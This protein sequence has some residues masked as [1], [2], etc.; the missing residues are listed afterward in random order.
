MSQYKTCNE[1]KRFLPNSSFSPTKGGKFGTRAKCKPCCAKA[2]KNY[3]MRNPTCAAE[4]SKTYR[5]RFPEIVKANNKKFRESNP[6]YAKNYH[7]EHRESELLR[8]KIKYWKNV[9]K[10][11]LRKKKFRENNPEAIKERN[12]KYRQNNPE[13]IRAKSQR[14]R[15]RIAQN[16]TFHVSKKELKRLY[17]AECFYCDNAAETID[18]VVPIVRGGSHGIGNLVP[19]CNHCNFS[20]A[21]RTIMEWRIWKIRL[22]I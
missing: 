16:L 13:I 5:E 15:A 4:Y 2:T 9:E 12:R 21:G 1:C 20:K 11:S 3:R 7:A 17:A 18:H 19:A 8:S 10:E 22:G 6:D 14:R